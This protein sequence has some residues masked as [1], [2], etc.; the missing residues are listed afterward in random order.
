MASYPACVLLDL[1]IPP[2]CAGCGAAGGSPC[3]ACWASFRR[4]DPPPARPPIGALYVPLSYEG[5]ARELVARLKYRN[6]RGALPW[7][8]TAMAAEL[9]AS[10]ATDCTVTWAPTTDARRR[11]RGFDH[12]E[13]LARAIAAALDR[14]VYRLLRRHPGA[15]QTG[16]S[17][18][19][20]RSNAPAFSPIASAKGCVVVVDD[21]VTTGT[22]IRA[23][24]EALREAGG[25]PIIGLIAALTPLKQFSD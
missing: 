12:G 16:L 14:P 20:R 7:L 8:A 5:P 21:V 6:H 25:T 11:E 24:A 4:P 17:P 13:L 9:P 23:A 15:P 22:T 2:G 18:Q 1:L 10:V 3:R 19:Q